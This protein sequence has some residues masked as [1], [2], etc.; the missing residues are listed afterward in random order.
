MSAVAA[1]P[2]YFLGP[3]VTHHGQPKTLIVDGQQRLTVLMLLLIWLHR[4][5]G[6]RDDAVA[7]LEPLVLFDLFGQRRFAVEDQDQPEERRQC[8]TTMLAGEQIDTSQDLSASIRNMV[9]RDLDRPVPAAVGDPG[10]RS[11]VRIPAKAG[12]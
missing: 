1:Y 9:A 3:I 11:S 8:L 4:V 10:G 5:Q 12:R 2:S 7:G 6:D